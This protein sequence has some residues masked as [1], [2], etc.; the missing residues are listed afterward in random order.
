MGNKKKQDQMNCKTRKSAIVESCNIFGF[1]YCNNYDDLPGRIKIF[2]SMLPDKEI[3]RPLVRYHR[4]VNKHSFRKI[5]Y[6]Y[7]IGHQLAIY[8]YFNPSQK[9]MNN[10]KELK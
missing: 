8:Y 9:M 7:G 10:C 4:N 6:K 5:A 2:Y 1:A 3:L